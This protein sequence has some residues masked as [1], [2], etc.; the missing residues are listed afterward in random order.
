ME[1]PSV[2]IIGRPNV[3]KSTLFNALIGKRRAIISDIPGTTRDMVAE[4]IVGEKKSFWLVDTAGLTNEK[5]DDLETSMQEQA[6]IAIEN[7]DVILLVLD[8]RAEITQDDHSVVELLRKQ[9]KPVVIAANKIDDGDATRA[10]E[11]AAFGLGVPMAV[12][13]KNYVHT[14]EL[15]DALEAALPDQ[16]AV[17]D[18]PDV[19]LRLAI[20]G[21]PNVGK[22][23][24]VNKLLGKQISLVSEVSGTTR[25]TIRDILTTTDGKRIELLDTAGIRRPGKIGR[26]IEYWSI[27]RTQQAIMDADVCVLLI[28]ALE[29]ITHQDKALVQ[30]IVAEGRG[31][32]LGINKFDLAYEKARQTE[33]TD[34]R[35]LEE[36]DM[37]GKD[38]NQ[39]K[40]DYWYYL[41]KHLSFIPW[42]SMSFF[43]AKTGKGVADIIEAA[44]GVGIEREKRVSTAELNRYLPD[45][46]YGHVQPSVGT[47]IGKIKYMSQVDTSPPKF[48]IH[49]NNVQAFHWSYRRYIENKL[50]EKFGFHGTPMIIEL[51]DAMKDR[52]QGQ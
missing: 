49:V 41:H 44:L 48:L 38:M 50:R 33:E 8:A 32:L 21:R 31:L 17:A 34:E 45:I 7:A 4:R 15:Q 22:S 10:Y 25:D 37:W 16:T 47:K 39:I 5:G 40:K 20:V 43:S 14:W 29:G 27:V 36:V 9:P 51:R 18:V 13:G 1:L 26:G 12:S 24:L 19:D 11:M 30:R 2:A 42:A 3:G 28:D 52:R 46:L 6:K 35:E 23:T